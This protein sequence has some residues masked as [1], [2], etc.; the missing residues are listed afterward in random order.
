MKQ[1]VAPE[2][3][4]KS[5]D[6]VANLAL[7][8]LRHGQPDRAAALGIAAMAFGPIT[9][10]LGLIAADAFLRSDEPEQADAILSRFWTKGML[11]SEPDMLQLKAAH[12]LQAKALHK[13]GDTT[14]ARKELAKASQMEAIA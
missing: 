4:L 8:Y 3:D 9:P 10:Q 1:F 12:I 5:F 11:R 2:P 14:G 7:I 13:T 6:V